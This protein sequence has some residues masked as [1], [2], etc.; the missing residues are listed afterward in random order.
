MKFS[1]WLWAGLSLPLLGMNVAAA[2]VD[3]AA[4]RVIV[5]FRAE[6]SAL[7]QASAADQASLLGRRAGLNLRALSGP[8]PDMRVFL[9]EGAGADD[10]LRLLAAQPEVEYALPDRMRYIRAMPND[11]MFPGQWYLRAAQPAAINMEAAWDIGRGD[12]GTVVAVID[13]GVRPDHPDLAGKLV[14]GYDFISNA[15]L[16]ADGDGRDADPSD[17]GDYIDAAARANSALVAV[18]GS[19]ALFW[20]QPSSWHGTRVAGLIAAATDNGVGVAGAGWN[21]RVMPLRALGKCGGFDSDILAAMRWAA[22][23]EVPGLPLNPTPARVINLSLGAP[24]TC[25]SAYTDT[26][27]ELTARG[28]LVVASAGN[29]N[30][31]VESPA[32]CPGVLAVGGLRNVGTKV[33]YSSFGPEIGVSAPAGNCVTTG[34]GEPCLFSLDTTT[35]LG[36]TTPGLNGYTDQFTQ[37]NYGT[38]FSAPL[39]AATAG[40]MFD[41]NA[42][43][44]PAQVINLIKANA[45]AFPVEAGLPTCPS[46]NVNSQ[47][48]CTTTTC[49]AGMLDAR[50][51]LA[52]VTPSGNGGNGG[53]GGGGGGGAF[54]AGG[55]LGLFGLLGIA[56]LAGRRRD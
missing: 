8:A 35:N 52:A 2:A 49:G 27:P 25:T 50:A 23:L 46:T 45:R 43:L 13:T 34:I 47:C 18:C 53:G 33:G 29:A 56:W 24:G 42:G 30:G 20:D 39:V 6:A 22:G 41:R 16:A 55:L 19:G 1:I 36:S 44:T 17:P 7:R 4:T 28:V 14:A 31:A 26:I 37:A 21:L 5:K 54:D 11:A 12:N 9:A 48:N 10:T 32:N 3:D 51:A 15:A 38:S 40:L